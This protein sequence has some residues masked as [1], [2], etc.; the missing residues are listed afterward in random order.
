MI[1]DQLALAL[2]DVR[3]KTPWGGAS[4]R[5]LTAAYLRFTLKAQAAKSMSDFV[6]PEQCDLFAQKKAPW[7]YQGAP[8]LGGR[9]KRRPSRGG[10]DHG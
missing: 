2:D 7:I 10:Y 5:E 8:L 6:D 1:S 3:L 4:P 9:Q